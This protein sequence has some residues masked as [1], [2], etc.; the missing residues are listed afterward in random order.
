V[1]HAI[2]L[3][4]VL[5]VFWLLLSGHLAPLLLTLG[6]LSVTWVVYLAHRMDV[7][8]HEGQSLHLT[9]WAPAYWI[10]LF[11][12]I[13]KSN[14]DV[15]QRIWQPKPDIG[16]MMIRLKASQKSTLGRVIYANSITLTPGTITTNLE[17]PEL[18][19]HALTPTA[20]KALQSGEMDRRVTRMSESD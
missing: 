11:G 6:G 12:E 1:L 14:I 20:A 17:G 5:F 3:A 13:I 10:W 18:E 4:V 8:D 9:L 7:V 15:A 19:V 16:P 2:G